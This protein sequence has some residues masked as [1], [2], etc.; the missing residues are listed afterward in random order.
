[1]CTFKQE[2]RETE[3]SFSAPNLGSKRPDSTSPTATA[4]TTSWWTEMWWSNWFKY[5]SPINHQCCISSKKASSVVTL[6]DLIKNEKKKLHMFN[7][8]AVE[9][10]KQ[11]W[12]DLIGDSNNIWLNVPPI[13]S[14][15]YICF[16]STEIIDQLKSLRFMPGDVNQQMLLCRTPFQNVSKC[17]QSQ[18][19]PGFNWTTIFA[20]SRCGTLEDFQQET[21]GQGLRTIIFTHSDVLKVFISVPPFVGSWDVIFTA[22]NTEDGK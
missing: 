15:L 5:T 14:H 4:F 19:E 10:W 16:P 21:G 6:Y 9:K 20:F 11:A 7:G 22:R 2:F 18:P 13:S 17:F 1:M 12:L 8:N 3:S